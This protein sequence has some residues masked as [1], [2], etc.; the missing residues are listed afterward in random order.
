MTTAADV[1][2]ADYLDDLRDELLDLPADRRRELVREIEAHIGQARAQ[3]DDPFSEAEVRTLLARLGTPEEIAAEAW[4][5]DD[6]E[7]PAPAIAPPS[8][9]TTSSWREPAAIVLLLLGGFIAG[10][11]WLVGLVLLWWSPRWSVVD[12][13]I[14]T[15]ILPGG[16]TASM[17]I[18]VSSASVEICP[19][20]SCSSQHTS[21]F[22]LDTIL[23]AIALIS[24]LLTT[25]YLSL[26]L[27]WSR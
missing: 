2:V 26:A 9:A 23:L 13:L 21:W 25:L 20:T 10:I 19:S 15:F 24:P 4:D 17:F 16:L 22:T 5:E 14:G 27:R 6:E 3:L 7:D 8:P 12:K 18:L 1:A 11:G